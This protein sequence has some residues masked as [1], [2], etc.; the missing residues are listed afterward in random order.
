MRYNYENFL[1]TT[2]LKGIQ[3]ISSGKVLV[4]FNEALILVSLYWLYGVYFWYYITE[5]IR[6]VYTVYKIGI[7]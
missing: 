6:T 5:A 2:T 1:R 7:H 4:V 3:Q